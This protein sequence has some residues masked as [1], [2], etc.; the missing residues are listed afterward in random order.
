MRTELTLT[1]LSAALLV[2]VL[3]T[4]ALGCNKTDDPKSAETIILVTG[5]TVSGQSVSSATDT[6]ATIDYT[7]NPRHPEAVT[8]WNDVTLTSYSVSFEPPVVAPMAGAISTG[9]CP[10]AQGACAIDIVLVPNGS[11][12]GLVAGTSVVA[13]I[14]VEGRDVNDNPV[15][16]TAS[17]AITFVP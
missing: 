8:V 17:A 11:K 16:F 9:F 3:V 10:A 5:V 4:V 14:A 2:T 13:K 12:I 1:R 15:N 6:T 7:M